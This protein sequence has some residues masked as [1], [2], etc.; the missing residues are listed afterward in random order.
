MAEPTKPARLV[1]T[2]LAIAGITG[3]ILGGAERATREP[4]RAAEAAAKDQALRAVLGRAR[5]FEPVPVPKGYAL[6]EVFRASADGRVVGFAYL[7]SPKGYGGPVRLVVGI[8]SDGKVEAVRILSMNETP[9]LGSKAADPAFIDQYARKAGPFQVVK[10]PPGGSSEIQAISGATITSRAVTSGV[11]EAVRCF[12]DIHA[13][14]AS[15]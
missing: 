2:L 11:D 3:L 8:G 14:E 13:K 7:A 1:V 12:T 4:I 9:G 10:N 5:S 6:D 15:R